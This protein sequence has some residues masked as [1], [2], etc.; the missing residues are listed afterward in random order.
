MTIAEERNLRMN[1]FR[2][3]KTY[4]VE[5]IIDARSRHRDGD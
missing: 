3:E 4:S 2:I 1:P 5:R